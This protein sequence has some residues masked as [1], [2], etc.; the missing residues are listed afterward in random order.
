MFVYQRLNPLTNS[1]SVKISFRGYTRFSDTPIPPTTT[2]WKIALQ[3]FNIAVENRPV[4]RSPSSLKWPSSWNTWQQPSIFANCVFLVEGAAW[5]NVSESLIWFLLF[6]SFVSR[7]A[8]CFDDHESSWALSLR[9][10]LYPYPM[11]YGMIRAKKRIISG[12]YPLS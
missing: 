1:S 7:S 11:I 9:N 8:F 12:K 10:S 3:Q 6:S 4:F 2:G 5:A